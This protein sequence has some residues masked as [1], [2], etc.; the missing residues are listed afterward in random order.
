MS[1]SAPTV[2]IID[3]EEVVRDSCSYALAKAGYDVD[4]AED[5]PA[6]IEKM[7]QS[8]PDLVLLDLKMPGLSGMDVLTKI[9]E[10]DRNIVTVVITG[11]ATVS[12]AVEAMK[13]GAY[14]F[15]PKP[16]TPEELRIII[17]R[18]LEKR[19]LVLETESLQQEKERMKR[20][21]ITMVSHELRSP[22]AAVLQYLEAVLGGA[23]GEVP[24]D[25]RHILERMKMRIEGLLTMTRDWLNLAQIEKG[26]LTQDFQSLDLAHI[27]SEAVELMGPEAAA[28]NVTIESKVPGSLPATRGDE[29]TLMRVFINLIAN[30]IKYNVPG[31]QVTISGRT[32]DSRVQVLVSDTGIGIPDDDLPFIFD[33]FYRVKRNATEGTGLGLSIAKKIVEA[34]SGTISVRSEVGKGST[35]AVSL[36]RS[37]EKRNAT[38]ENGQ[39]GEAQSE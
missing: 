38:D 6:G 20:N 22:L 17:G 33:E 19:R 8:P 1:E 35:F 12:S 14:D 4:T 37:Q 9:P 13:R 21:F 24:A 30:A 36:P 5:G 10:V 11:Y 23:V 26:R 39:T 28:K 32:D 27:I 15:L 16:F 2:L 18:A 34:H 7:G 31:G 29:K 3:D 25:Q